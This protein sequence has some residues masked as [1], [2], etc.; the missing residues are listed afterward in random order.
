M[1]IEK[2][3]VAVKKRKEDFMLLNAS[4][5][6]MDPRVLTAHNFSKAMIL[7]K[8]NAKMAMA[9]TST[10]ALEA[11]ATT[12]ASTPV[13][14]SLSTPAMASA[15]ATEQAEVFMLDGAELTQQATSNP[16]L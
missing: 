2:E 15:S 10:P 12:S 9:S 14:A 8:I 11:V 13:S 4:A 1:L 3:R 5:A 6:G 7:D 16:F